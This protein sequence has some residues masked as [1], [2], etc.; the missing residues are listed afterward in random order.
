MLT[1]NRVQRFTDGIA[2]FSRE[3]QIEEP[4]DA[5]DVQLAEIARLKFEDRTV[6]ERRYYD[7]KQTGTEIV[8]MI[9]IPK[10]PGIERE[11][12]VTIDSDEYLV[13]QVQYVSDPPIGASVLDVS[14]KRRTE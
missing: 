11:M 4:G 6:G 7:A 8:R 14:L 5:P 13:E 9:R 10:C 2:V 1:R 3:V 12:R